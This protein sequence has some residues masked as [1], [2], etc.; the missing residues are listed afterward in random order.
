MSEKIEIYF[1]NKNKTGAKSTMWIKHSECAKAT[2]TIIAFYNRMIAKYNLGNPTDKQTIETLFD[3]PYSGLMDKHDTIIMLAT[4]DDSYT[5]VKDIPQLIKAIDK[6]IAEYHNSCDMSEFAEL[7]AQLKN[8][9]E[10]EKK[11]MSLTFAWFKSSDHRKDYG[12]H[13][14]PRRRDD[15]WNVF[16]DYKGIKFI[17]K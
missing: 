11:V 14:W 17:G 2:D 15:Y 13:F 7:S 9:I 1:A 12:T 6:H 8:L 4:M 3:Y 10:S 5:L 16:T